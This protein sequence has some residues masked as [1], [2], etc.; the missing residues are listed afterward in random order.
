MGKSDLTGSKMFLILARA[1][2]LSYRHVDKNKNHVFQKTTPQ[3]SF[4][5]FLRM[6]VGARASTSRVF[7]F[8]LAYNRIGIIT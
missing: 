8:M 1:I 3:V 5:F 4:F 7:A 2:E 6:R